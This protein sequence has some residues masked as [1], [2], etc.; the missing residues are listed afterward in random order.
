LLKILATSRK[1]ASQAGGKVAA[2]E[3]ALSQS[4]WKIFDDVDADDGEL[5]IALA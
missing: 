2:P 1:K 5:D 4:S 3:K